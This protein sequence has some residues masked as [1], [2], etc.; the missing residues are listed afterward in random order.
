[1][2]DFV[3]AGA[4][5]ASSSAGF[6]PTER[7]PTSFTSTSTLSH[8]KKQPSKSHKSSTA[9]GAK[10]TRTVNGMEDV[11][12]HDQVRTWSEVRIKT[13][14]HRRTNVEGFYYRFVG[15]SFCLYFIRTLLPL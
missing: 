15:T 3:S 10:P 11:F 14:E 6:S 5:T 4:P 13:W 7:K 1:M 9:K 12:S 2:D 8:K